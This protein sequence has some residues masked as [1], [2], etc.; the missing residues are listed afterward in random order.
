MINSLIT[1]L[2]ISIH[3]IICEPI[4]DNELNLL[5][6]SY[7]NNVEKKY[8]EANEFILNGTV[9]RFNI[10]FRFKLYSL[11]LDIYRMERNIEKLKNQKTNDHK[12]SED[13]YKNEKI[14]LKGYNHLLNIMEGTKNFYL[15]IIKTIKTIFLA[16]VLIIF[17]GGIF[18]LLIMLYI[19][20]TKYKDYSALV[21]KDKKD[22]K[23]EYK[24]V[25]IFNNFFKF[26]KKIK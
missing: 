3:K 26:N 10:P 14:F 23:S 16:I 11:K 4:S 5:I 25:K 2:L 22:K 6:N 15:K 17:L 7:Q 19:S 12:Y 21:E 20:K 24:V 13:Y 1:F 8:A 9:S 18:A